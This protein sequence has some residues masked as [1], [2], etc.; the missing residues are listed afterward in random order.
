MQA[1]PRGFALPRRG[2]IALAPIPARAA[3]RAGVSDRR[4]DPNTKR[5]YAAVGVVA[6]RVTATGAKKLAAKSV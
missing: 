1:R 2:R 6:P 3:R 5:G 4:I